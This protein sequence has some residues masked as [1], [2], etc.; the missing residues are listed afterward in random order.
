MFTTLQN[1]ILKPNCLNRLGL[2]L[3]YLSNTKGINYIDEYG[4][5]A[6]EEII[7]KLDYSIND[8]KNNLDGKVISVLG[9]GTQG[10]SQSANLKD[11]NMDVIL[12]LRKGGKSWNNALEDGWEEDKNLFTIEEATSR[13]NIIQC[14]LS[15]FGQIEQWKNIEPNLYT[16]D[17]LCFSHGFGI[18]YKSNTKIIP[19]NDINVIMVAPKCSGN[20]VRQHF[21]NGRGFNS[22]YAIYQNHNNAR[23]ICYSYSF[24][25]GNNY[26]FETTFDKEVISDLTGERC[27]LMGM[28]QAAFSAQYK[29]LREN[30][31]SPLEAYNETVEE[32]LNSLYP[33]IS[34]NGMEWMYRNCSTTAQRGAIDWSKK[35]EEKL[36]PMIEECYESVKNNT[37]L[38][39][40]MEC[41]KNPDY[42]VILDEELDTMSKQELWRV[43]KQIKDIT[44]ELNTN[45]NTNTNNI[46]NSDFINRY[47]KHDRNWLKYIS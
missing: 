46:Q 37:E 20:T 2:G 15:D 10:I 40:I 4:D 39:I 31:H 38:N 25:I 13:G 44:Y 28:I 35:F 41:N 23:E 7:T 33:L 14:L 11:N 30:G 8:C 32:A 45:T 22:S 6:S 26:I 3:R 29:V 9:Y 1:S 24:L 43:S 17:T 42:N 19:P 18:H 47:S 36:I 12:G 27:I 16:N 34:Q 21:L 5:D